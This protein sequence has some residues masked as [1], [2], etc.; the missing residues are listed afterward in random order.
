MTLTTSGRLAS[1]AATA[2][3]L[4]LCRSMRSG[5][6]SMPWRVRKA[7]NG[8]SAEPRSRSSVTRAL[9]M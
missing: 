5:S 1:Q 6:V 3:A 7:L 9:M 8:E 2:S 4:T